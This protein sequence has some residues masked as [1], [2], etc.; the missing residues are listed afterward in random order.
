MLQIGLPQAW[1][2]S[3]SEGFAVSLQSLVF[4][5]FHPV[6]LSEENYRSEEGRELLLV[7]FLSLY[8]LWVSLACDGLDTMLYFYLGKHISAGPF[9]GFSGFVSFAFSWLS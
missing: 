2:W 1:N 4:L 9:I 3:Q 8:I 5:M 6:H 7:V